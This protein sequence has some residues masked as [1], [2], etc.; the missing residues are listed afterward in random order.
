MRI[1]GFLESECQLPLNPQ[2]SVGE[3]EPCRETM[4]ILLQFAIQTG[5]CHPPPVHHFTGI[6]LRI[7]VAYAD[8]DVIE[9]V[10]GNP[11]IEFRPI[12]K[13]ENVI[14]GVTES[15]LLL[16]PADSRSEWGFPWTGVGT[17]GVRPQSARM[18]LFRGPL[19]K[20]HVTRPV[21]D[22]DRNRTVKP[23]FPMSELLGDRADL[24]VESIDQNDDFLSCHLLA[25]EAGV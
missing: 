6:G 15:H 2:L 12:E 7:V 3:R 1:D 20:Q 21:E 19:L 4:R 23:P 10:L 8:E 14:Q 16:Q 25:S 24:V 5:R 18:I 9:L 13:T 17:A 22:E 11:R